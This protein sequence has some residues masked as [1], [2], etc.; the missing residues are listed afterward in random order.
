MPADRLHSQDRIL[1]G[2]ALR[3]KDYQRQSVAWMV[4][5]ESRNLNA[6]FW[7][8]WQWQDGGSELYFGWR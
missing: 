4:D 3:M 8:T 7:E 2:L 6:L 1:P 5:M